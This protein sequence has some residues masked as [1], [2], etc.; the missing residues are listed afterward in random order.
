MSTRSDTPPQSKHIT[1]QSPLEL[2]LCPFSVSPIPSPDPDNYLLVS[3][4]L[5]GRIVSSWISY[6]EITQ[7]VFFM[8]LDP[9]LSIMFW[10]HSILLY[11]SVMCYFS[12][13]WH[14]I[15]FHLFTW[16]MKEISYFFRS[17]LYNF[18]SVMRKCY[19]LGNPVYYQFVSGGT[20]CIDRANPSLHTLF[21]SCCWHFCLLRNQSSTR[22]SDELSNSNPCPWLSRVS[23]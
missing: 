7:T 16:K 8:Y 3:L 19:S 10:I 2:S 6:Y 14:H 9:T 17:V 12:L 5:Y 22:V 11:I 20:N 15:K 4:A 18:F 23:V 1:L 21:F 13:F